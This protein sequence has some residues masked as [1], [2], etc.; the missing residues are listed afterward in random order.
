MQTLSPEKILAVWEAGRDQHEIDRALTLLAAATPGVNRAELASLTIGERDTRLLH[1]RAA[2][3]GA[4]ATGVSECPECATRIEFP[5]D[6]SAFTSRLRQTSNGETADGRVPFRLPNSRD[7]AEVANATDAAEGLQ[8]L[9][10]RCVTDT[11]VECGPQSRQLSPNA[12]DAIGHAMLQADP[13]AEITLALACPDCGA[14]WQIPFDVADFF[15]QEIAD[16]AK[17]LLREI[18]VLARTYGWSEREILDLPAQRRR[19]YLEL[20][21]A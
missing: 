16:Q 18:D 10:A 1:L 3:F 9:I 5:V 12:L 11:S 19:T 6:T 13:A 21:E 8:R 17:R 14:R 7:L 2:H 15:W 4:A 20:I